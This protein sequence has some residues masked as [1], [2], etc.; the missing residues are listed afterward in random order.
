MQRVT[1]KATGEAQARISPSSGNAVSGGSIAEDGTITTDG[2][3][4]LVEF[5]VDKGG[6]KVC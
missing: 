4:C 5:P 2:G 1:Y 6:G 3:I